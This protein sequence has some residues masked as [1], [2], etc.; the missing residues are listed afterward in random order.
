MTK[1]LKNKNLYRTLIIASFIALNIGILF[2][3]SQ[4]LLYLNTGADRSSILHLSV[5]NEEV[6]LP[7]V[8]WQDT[9]NPGRPIT[10]HTLEMIQSD[11]LKAWYVRNVA[12][13][14]NDPYGID[15][16]YTESARE[17]IY[18]TIASH[19]SAN[20]QVS[21]TTLCHHL[22]L[23]FYSEDGQL[24]VFTDVN[25]KQYQRVYKDNVLEL[26]HQIEASYKVVV[27]LED[28]FWKVRHM[29]KELNPVIKDTISPYETPL[30]T[31]KQ[32]KIY[33]GENLFKMKGINYYPQQTP[34]DMFGDA[35]DIDI[36]SED[37]TIIKE[38]GLNTIR[39]FVQYEDFG[40]AKVKSEKIE[41]LQ[42]VLDLA[43]VRGLKVIVTLFD[44]YGNYD[45]LDWTMTHRHA[46][47][48]VSYFKEH[49]AILAWDIKN[50]PNLDFEN[51][52]KITVLAWLR[53][54][55]IQIKQYDPNHLVTIGWSDIESALLLED[56]IDLVSFH[57]YQ[58]LESF[59]EKYGSLIT[60]TNKPI[61]L[62]EFGLSSNQGLWN[63]FGASEESQAI[64][65][66]NFQQILKKNDVHY[67]TWTLYDF[68]NVP[69]EVS[70]SMPWQ[71]DKQKYF[72][73]IGINGNRKKAF[74]FIS[75]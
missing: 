54:M 31:V 59:E 2:G 28:G 41:K 25:T 75:E 66:E 32:N 73:F 42:Q 48:I 69:T 5:Q 44:F 61:I 43:E 47:Q 49:R 27:L 23:D 36:I 30:I 58:G 70:G 38:A 9:T 34:W 11:Y 24:A 50:E 20:I 22:S 55:I 45:V 64:Y 15:D 7:K 26:E 14:S 67:L 74:K 65:Y 57:Y 3:I 17:N 53:E 52:G 21:A 40:K 4:V 72:G 39:V 6:Y 1:S 13:M 35:F 37:F 62:Q 46:E 18:K 19:V 68:E 56:Q 51:R 8:I 63:P 60:K 10:R 71:K 16:F 33:I 29:V 12:Y